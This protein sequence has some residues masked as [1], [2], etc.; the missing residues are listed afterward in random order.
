MGLF[1]EFHLIQNFAPANLNRDDTGAPKDAL[2]GG[3]RRARVS[4][5]CF[6]RAVREWFR[7]HSDLSSN[8]IG[9]RTLRLDRMLASELASIGL[10][11]ESKFNEI[12]KLALKKKPGKDKAEKPEEGDDDSALSYLMFISPAEIAAMAEV[13]A[14]HAD[15]IK[16]VAAK[17]KPKPADVPDGLKAALRDCLRKLHA[18]DIAL[19]GRMLTDL[20][21]AN[22]HAACQVAHALSTHRVELE[23]DYFTA[24][25]D[26][27][28]PGETGAPMIGSVE[29]NSATFYRFAVVD[30]PKLIDNLGK[31]RELALAGLRA[32]ADAMARALPTGKQN[33][34]AAHNPPSFVG[35]VLRHSSPV[36]LANAFERPVVATRDAS[37][38][39]TSVQRLADQEQRLAR[40][41]GDGLDAWGWLDDTGRWPEDLGTRHA[42]LA[43]LLDWLIAEVRRQLPTGA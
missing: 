25:D 6:K 14:E 8:V 26:K 9:S 36:N 42:S 13:I 2:F 23:V 31:D 27:R 18:V 12:V 35:A 37:L 7:E 40:L 22:Q 19:F 15:A 43:S 5:Q 21:E 29:F 3:Y 16:S 10:S 11:D 34:F 24:V 41:Y 20:P 39:E 30:V 1:A 38:T 33:S 28:S 32:F 17:K 4:S